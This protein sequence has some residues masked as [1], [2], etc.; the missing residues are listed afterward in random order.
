MSG[1][2]HRE[3]LE[4]LLE[5]SS[6]YEHERDSIRQLLGNQEADSDTLAMSAWH[7]QKRILQRVEASERRDRRVR[8]HRQAV[9]AGKGR[10]R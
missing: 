5:S 10:W 2:G 6:L 8:D 3:R 4:R 9:L 1:D 7:Y